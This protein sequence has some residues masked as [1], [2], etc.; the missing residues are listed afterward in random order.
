MFQTNDLNKCLNQ[1]R[2]IVKLKNAKEGGKSR[3]IAGKSG[4]SVSLS[5]SGAESKTYSVCTCYRLKA[6]DYQVCMFIYRFF[7]IVMPMPIAIWIIKEIQMRLVDIPRIKFFGKQRYRAN[8][9]FLDG[10]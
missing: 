4:S 8:W 2:G 5:Q 10:P 3:A 6:G 1:K 7:S 9:P